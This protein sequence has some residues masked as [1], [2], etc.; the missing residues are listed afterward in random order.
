MYGCNEDGGSSESPE[1]VL[2][3]RYAEGE[4]DHSTYQ[5]MLTE[6]KG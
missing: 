1:Q 2:E 4:I 3:R 5:Q 6:L